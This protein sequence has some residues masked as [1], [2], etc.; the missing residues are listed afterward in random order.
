MEQRKRVKAGE[1]ANGMLH[2][3]NESVKVPKQGNDSG[4]RSL[5]G[6]IIIGNNGC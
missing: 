4:R 5:Y 6:R 1:S 3:S 2:N